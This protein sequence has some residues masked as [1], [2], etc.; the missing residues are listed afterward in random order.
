VPRCVPAR[1]RS[2][3][4]RL[5]HSIGGVLRQLRH[6]VGCQCARSG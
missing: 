1:L 3:P 6:D 2:A 5:S 4:Q